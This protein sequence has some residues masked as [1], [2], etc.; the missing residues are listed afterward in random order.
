MGK[1]MSNDGTFTHESLEDRESIVRYLEALLVGLRQGKVELEQDG[2]ALELCPSGLLSF[3]VKA[4]RKGERAKLRL[5][6]Q[7]QEQA[8][9][10]SDAPLRIRP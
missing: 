1:Q 9:S 8:R 10:Q 6:L 4:K 2:E 7:W 5:K 3:Q